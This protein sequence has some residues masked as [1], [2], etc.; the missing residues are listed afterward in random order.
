MFAEDPLKECERRVPFEIIL[1][2]VLV[3]KGD[4][5]VID[6]HHIADDVE[7]LRRANWLT[8]FIDLDEPNL[9]LHVWSRGISLSPLIRNGRVQRWNFLLV[10]NCEPG[11][12]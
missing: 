11:Q 9:G 2:D 10:K 12:S 3:L 8:L 7:I 1:L 4:G 6:V 5:Q